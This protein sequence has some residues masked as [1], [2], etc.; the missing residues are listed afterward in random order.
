LLDR[1]TLKIEKYMNKIYYN[2]LVRDGIPDE[3]TS[4]GRAFETRVMDDVEY[5][6]EVLKKVSEEA[7][8]LGLAQ[9]HDS[10]VKEVADLFDI[11]DV[12]VELKG[13]SRDEIEAAREKKLEKRGG[14]SQENYASVE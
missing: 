6:R 14:V 9:D 1:G 13:I 12:L 4:L 5:E 3:L 2:K 10:A 7:I 11:I 8:E